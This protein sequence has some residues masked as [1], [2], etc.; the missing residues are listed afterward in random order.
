MELI[1][2]TPNL[3][4]FIYSLENLRLINYFLIPGYINILIFFISINETHFLLTHLH[5]FILN[6]HVSYTYYVYFAII[7]TIHICTCL[8][9]H[10]INIKI[11]NLQSVQIGAHAYR[12]A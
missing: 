3:E 7:V 8:Q 12:H 1:K 5:I 4:Y 11:T 10:K 6:A 2:L 9:L